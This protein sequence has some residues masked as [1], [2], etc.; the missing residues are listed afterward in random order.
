MKLFQRWV[1]LLKAKKEEKKHI[2]TE[3]ELIKEDSEFK[4]DESE[5]DQFLTKGYTAK[6]R[7]KRLTK[8]RK[9]K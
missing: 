9:K 6:K 3:E 1:A 4:R 7:R 5:L 8:P 2:V